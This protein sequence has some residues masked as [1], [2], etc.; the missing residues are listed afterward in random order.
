M[1]IPGHSGINGNEKADKR[2]KEANKEPLHTFDYITCNDI[3]ILAKEFA[4]DNAATK[5]N[6]YQHPYKNFNPFGEKNIYP[7]SALCHQA[8]IFTRLRIGHTL[9]THAHLLS[10]SPEPTCPFCCSNEFTTLHLI[11]TCPP[12]QNIRTS[13]FS[14]IKPSELLKQTTV[15]NL[16]KI[17]DYVS[18]CKLKL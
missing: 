13:F 4:A 14:S 3:K 16:N 8:K 12:L 5:W 15:C 6:S 9:M 1:W 2:A 18:R 7:P 17:C 11:D 10:S